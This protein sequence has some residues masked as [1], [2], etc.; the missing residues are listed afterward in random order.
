MQSIEITNA[1]RNLRAELAKFF[2]GKNV[3]CAIALDKLN[4]AILFFMYVYTQVIHKSSTIMVVCFFELL[5]LQISSHWANSIL[6]LISICIICI[7]LP[8]SF[9]HEI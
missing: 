7:Y 3:A 4:G 2:I 8:P 9:M 1:M 5:E 6:K